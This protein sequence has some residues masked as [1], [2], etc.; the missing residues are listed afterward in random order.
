RVVLVCLLL[1]GFLF[2]LKESLECVTQIEQQVEAIGHLLCLGS[3]FARSLRIGSCT[4]TADDFDS[5]M[6]GEPGLEGLSLAIRQ[7]IHNAMSLQINQDRA[8]R[9]PLAHGPV[10]YSK[11]AWGRGSRQRSTAQ[12]TEQGVSTD[13]HQH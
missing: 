10:V 3:S 9:S 11:H 1:Q 12:Q 13:R 5:R 4:V 7:D 6:S 8:V 2:P